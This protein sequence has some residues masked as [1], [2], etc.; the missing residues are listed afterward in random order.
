M[1]WTLLAVSIAG[2]NCLQYTSAYLPPLLIS[3]QRSTE[4]VLQTATSGVL[5]TTADSCGSPFHTEVV[6]TKITVSGLQSTV[7]TCIFHFY[8]HLPKV[9]VHIYLTFTGSHTQSTLTDIH[10]NNI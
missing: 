8:L 4:S 10:Q 6:D 7:C 2:L 9:R 1:E 5:C 3:Q